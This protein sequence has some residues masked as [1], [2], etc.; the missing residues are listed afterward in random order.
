M[1]PNAVG[2]QQTV[3]KW[4]KIHLLS[5]GYMKQIKERHITF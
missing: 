5:F 1:N 4:T 2:V 3:P